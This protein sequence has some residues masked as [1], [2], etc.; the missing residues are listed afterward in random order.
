MPSIFNLQVRTNVP[1]SG[2]DIGCN[3]SFV[4]HNDLIANIVGQDVVVLAKGIDGLGILIEDV[5]RPCR[6][7]TVN[8]SVEGQGKVNTE[9]TQGQQADGK[10]TITTLTWYRYQQH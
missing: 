3:R 8:R 9:A 5:G 7:I 4:A 10:N 1:S 2:L 6:N